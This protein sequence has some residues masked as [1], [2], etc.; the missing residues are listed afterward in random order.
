MPH[1][2]SP[3]LVPNAAQEDSTL[4]D[5]PLDALD[6]NVDYGS[7]NDMTGTE[8]KINMKTEVKLEDIF[9]DDED[10]D[11]FQSSGTPNSKVESSPPAPPM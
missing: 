5:A 8:G 11:E 9:N 2:I 7:G 4:A 3:L 10:D 6:D 1:S